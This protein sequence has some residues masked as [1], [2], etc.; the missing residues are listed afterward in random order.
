MLEHGSAPQ[1]YQPL[2]QY[3]YGNQAYNII[4]PNQSYEDLA[5]MGLG[6]ATAH[7]NIH[8]A[9]QGLGSMHYLVHGEMTHYML[10]LLL[11]FRE[12]ELKRE[13]DKLAE[14]EYILALR[15]LGGGG[16]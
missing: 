15:N 1:H 16:S 5:F 9:N 13:L 10:G 2:P 4:L 8:R 3:N 11:E 12:T 6:L 7:K 14:I